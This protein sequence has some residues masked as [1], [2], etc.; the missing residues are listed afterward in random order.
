MVITFVHL[1]SL[2][3]QTFFK[4]VQILLL[5]RQVLLSSLHE[6]M[7]PIQIKRAS[8]QVHTRAC[9]YRPAH[10]F[11]TY[12]SDAWIHARTYVR[13]FRTYLGK[14]ASCSSTNRMTSAINLLIKGRFRLAI[15]VMIAKK[16]AVK[17]VSPRA[18]PKPLARPAKK[19][20]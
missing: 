1:F 12:H 2:Q 11:R 9:M 15:R 18:M 20:K 6:Y 19:F 16:R 14:P 8:V 17:R 5:H 10:T 13:I 7:V 3:K 4:T